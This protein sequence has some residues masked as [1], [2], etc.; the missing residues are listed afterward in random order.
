MEK[1]ALKHLH[2]LYDTPI[3]HVFRIQ[4]FS[5][6]LTALIPHDDPVY[7]EIIELHRAGRY[8]NREIHMS[9]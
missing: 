6:G 8:W 1:R 5:R 4:E 2:E 9:T 3:H 7:R